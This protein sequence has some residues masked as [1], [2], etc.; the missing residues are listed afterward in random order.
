MRSTLAV[1]TVGL[2]SLMS[3]CT[4]PGTKPESA[5]AEENS[6]LSQNNEPSPPAAE[7]TGDLLYDI[8]VAEFA[9]RGEDMRLSAHRFFDAAQQTGDYRLARRA[10]QSAIY[11]HDYNLALEA[12]KFWVELS[13]SS[14]EA[15]QSVAALLIRNGRSSEALPH[16]ENILA[17][18]KPGRAHGYAMIGA[19]LEHEIDQE[20]SMSLMQQLVAAH[21][22]DPEALYTYASLASKQGKNHQ[23]YNLLQ[24]LLKEHPDMDRALVLNARVLYALGRN[25]EA[26][27]SLAHAVDN[28]P[29]NDQL[30][31]TYAR[32]LIDERQLKAA[33][34]QFSILHE[35]LP[36][37][38]E[39]IYA[40]ALLAIDAGDHKEARLRLKQL[41]VMD[42]RTDEAN[43]ML[44]QL[45]EQEKKTNEAIGYYQK[46]EQSDYYLD[47]QT[48]ITHLL[49]ESQGLDAARTY[50]HGVE[51]Q[52][53]Q[54]QIQLFIT[55]AELLREAGQGEQ[56]LELYNAVIGQYPKEINVLYARAMLWESL[57]RVDMM[58]Q[59]IKR[60]LAIDPDNAQA[61]NA[62]GYTL[63]DRTERYD[64][65]Y[66]M[67]AKAISQLPNDPAVLDSMGWVLYKL[68]RLDESLKYLQ[69]AANQQEDGE[70]YAH[71]GEVLWA[72]G[73]HADAQ[74]VW[75]QALKFAP[76]D[77]VLRQ[78]IQRHTP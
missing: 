40:L 30:R 8:L 74:K 50:L 23:A 52:S 5:A 60:I 47:A 66:A 36:D 59:D 48:R 14:I 31:L 62:M 21:P 70:I 4:T 65:A 24:P 68:G 25:Q 69:Q 13:P 32:L 26:L 18:S 3:A 61:L 39:V 43:Y 42:R 44:G 1:I 11:A 33:R 16:L 29:D 49:F 6:S 19:M 34:K 78:V 64:E 35:R 2:L 63:A 56:A 22:N 38:A 15:Q 41:L 53:E 67:I 71:L 37:D 45:A 54:E 10:T 12:A 77:A 58:E 73:R 55:E 72:L 28:N 57:D 9:G 75:N 27:E 7:L 76:D 17:L 46:V 20:A 51:A